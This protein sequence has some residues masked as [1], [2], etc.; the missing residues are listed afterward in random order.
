MPNETDDH[1][2]AL[3]ELESLLAHD[4]SNDAIRRR[5][6]GKSVEAARAKDAAHFL[7]RALRNARQ[8]NQ[9]RV[10][11]DIGLLYLEDGDR[12]RARRAFAQV[13]EGDGDAPWRLAAARRLL[14]L[15]AGSTPQALV[16]PL[17]VMAQLETDPEARTAAASE[18]L[19]MRGRARL[20]APSEIAAWRALWEGPRAEEAIAALEAL[21]EASGDR[22]GLCE[23]LA[24]RAERE[25]D[26]TAAQ[27]LALRSA[28]LCGT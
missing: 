5:Y 19:E 22:M 3:A 18:L 26:P 2:R 11:V 16:R 21:Y 12:E 25:V 28:E 24:R 27:A 1:S 20:D 14:D 7:S 8:E 17:A 13:V 6:I 23:V 9:A 15:Q 4:P 10:G